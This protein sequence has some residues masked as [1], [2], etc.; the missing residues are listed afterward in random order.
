MAHPRPSAVLAGLLLL[1]PLAACGAPSSDTAAPVV[2]AG[3]FSP[4]P[5]LPIFASPHA[6]DVVIPQYLLDQD[7]RDKRLSQAKAKVKTPGTTG[8]TSSA[9]GAPSAPSSAGPA[10][11]DADDFRATFQK[12]RQSVG[13]FVTDGCKGQSVGSGIVLAADLVLTD[14]HVVREGPWTFT[15]NKT[16]YHGTVIGLDPQEDVAL[17][18]L[19]ARTSAPALKLALDF[20]TV[21]TAIASIGY[22]GAVGLESESPSLQV[23]VVSG[24]NR[25]VD[26]QTGMLQTDAQASHGSSGGPVVTRDGVVVGMVDKFMEGSPNVVLE[27]GSPLAA[28]L[29]AGWKAH[30]T[31]YVPPC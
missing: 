14:A 18:R 13:Y 16:D 3:T 12:V 15:L 4:E 6:G 30:P 9:P 5:P 1:V 11:G 26:G 21:G 31:T 2:P 17:V 28:R 27:V 20:P 8:S 24:V 22:T 23:G 7:A 10:A 29:A 25:A 19:S